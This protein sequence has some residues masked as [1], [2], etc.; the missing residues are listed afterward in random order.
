MIFLTIRFLKLVKQGINLNF[1]ILKQF[2]NYLFL[3]C[4]F[5]LLN[6]EKYSLQTFCKK[7]K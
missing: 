1:T 3:F 7:T 5:L 6:S 2:K 4:H